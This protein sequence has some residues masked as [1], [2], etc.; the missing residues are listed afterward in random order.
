MNPV[1]YPG[2]KHNDFPFLCAIS[3][4]LFQILQL[5]LRRFEKPLYGFNRFQVSP[6]LNP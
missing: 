5:L 4:Q 3:N 2:T 1:L 6:A